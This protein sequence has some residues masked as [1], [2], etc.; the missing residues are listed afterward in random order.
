MRTTPT[1]AC[2]IDSNL[3]PMNLRREKTALE[4]VERY[5]RL[6]TDHPNRKLLESWQDKRRIQHKSLLSLS[7]DLE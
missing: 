2:E 3:E 6:E 5:K 1:A 7:K 4:T